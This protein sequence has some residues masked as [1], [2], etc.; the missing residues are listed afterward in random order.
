MRRNNL[1]GKSETPIF[2]CSMRL[3][4]LGWHLTR[5]MRY[6]I[7]S[8]APPQPSCEEKSMLQ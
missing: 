3:S 7:V 4:L 5:D 1:S 8:S 6:K 2:I